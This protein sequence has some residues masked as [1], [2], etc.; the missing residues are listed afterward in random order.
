MVIFFNIHVIFLS[1]PFNPLVEIVG[2]FFFTDFVHY[3][4]HRALHHRLFYKHFH[5]QHHT[6]KITTPFSAY[7]LHPVDSFTQGIPWHIFVYLFPFNSRLFA[8]G[9]TFLVIWT[10][11]VH[12][13]ES[14]LPKVLQP[15]VNGA[16]HH[17]DH[18][19]YY[20]YNYGQFTTLW[21]RVFGSYRLPGTHQGKGP[22]DD[23]M[24]HAMKTEKVTNGNTNGYSNGHTHTKEE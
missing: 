10:F 5:K 16:A 23:V 9:F 15:I 3:W 20:N 11:I 21:D 8:L 12:D 6:W 24:A 13:N 1:G 17:T 19:M 2:L 4:F 14:R 18:H 7:A 22:L